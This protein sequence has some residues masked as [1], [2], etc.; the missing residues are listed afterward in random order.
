MVVFSFNISKLSEIIKNPKDREKEERFLLNRYKEWGVSDKETIQLDEQTIIKIITLEGESEENSARL[1]VQWAN[2]LGAIFK[3]T[4]LSSSQL[5]NLFGEVRAIQNIGFANQEARRRFILLIPKIQYASAR[6][7][8]FGMSGLANIL[9]RGIHAVHDDQR[10]FDRFVEFF[11]AILAY[12]K[13][14]GGN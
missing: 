11:E 4:G 10:N 3:S 6:A 5:R 2:K 8:T 9:E 13:A 14:Y 12:H 1:L 7:K